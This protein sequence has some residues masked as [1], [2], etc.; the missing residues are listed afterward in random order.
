MTELGPKFPLPPIIRTFGLHMLLIFILISDA[1]P[2]T[3]RCLIKFTLTDDLR[4]L[5]YIGQP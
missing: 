3:L 5:P 2:F 4:G 1:L